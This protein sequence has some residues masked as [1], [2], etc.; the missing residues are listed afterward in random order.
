[1]TTKGLECGRVAGKAVGNGVC[2]GEAVFNN[3]MQGIEAEFAME[4]P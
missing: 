1:M 3:E 2:E 4:V